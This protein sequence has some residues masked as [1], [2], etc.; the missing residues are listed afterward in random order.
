MK[1]NPAYLII[2]FDT[3]GLSSSTYSGDNRGKNV[4]MAEIRKTKHSVAYEMVLRKTEHRVPWSKISKVIY[5]VTI[6]AREE[7]RNKK[8]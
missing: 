2:E 1:E 8:C 5:D 4:A 6:E 3:L 7:V